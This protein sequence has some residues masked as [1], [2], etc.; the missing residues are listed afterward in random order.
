MTTSVTNMEGCSI[1]VSGRLHHGVDQDWYG[2]PWRR[3]AG[4]GPSTA[5]NIL[6]YLGDRVPLQLPT[7]SRDQMR[8]LMDWVWGYVTPGLRGLNTTE[9]FVTGMDAI[10]AE[11][12]SPLRCHALDV[13]QEMGSRPNLSEVAAFLREGL[14]KDCPVAFLNLHN[15]GLPQLEG[16]HWITLLAVEEG[17]NRLVVQAVD[18]GNRLTLDLGQWLRSSRLG[19][20]FVRIG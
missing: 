10:F 1:P 3:L 14:A 16:W 15:G 11:L 20:G 9:R 7:H 19:G 8:E 13:P 18:N 2:L 6:R 5:S 17:E 12:G 4:C